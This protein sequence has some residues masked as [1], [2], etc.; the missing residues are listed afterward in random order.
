MALTVLNWSKFCCIFHFILIM[1]TVWQWK[2]QGRV[3]GGKYTPTFE[4]VSEIVIEECN[5]NVWVYLFT[6]QSENFGLLTPRNSLS[7]SATAV[8][9]VLIPR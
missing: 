5:K 7:G 4:R 2:S 6:P 9:T 8:W 3:G 1:A